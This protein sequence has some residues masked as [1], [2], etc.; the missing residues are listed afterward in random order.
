MAFSLTQLTQKFSRLSRRQMEM[1]YLNH[2]VSLYDVERRI[3]E[4]E[5]GKFSNA[6]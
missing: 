6:R 2:S 5:R 1:N 4:I 3:Q